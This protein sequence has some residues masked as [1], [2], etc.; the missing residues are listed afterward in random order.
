MKKCLLSVSFIFIA[1]FICT[2]DVFAYHFH[3]DALNA[4]DKGS[5]VLLCEY[6]DPDDP[7]GNDKGEK[8]YYHFRGAGTNSP[9]PTGFWDVFY[10]R[11]SK[12]ETLESAIDQSLLTYGDFVHVFISNNRIS[13]N[14]DGEKFPQDTETNFTC[15]AYSFTDFDNLNEICFGDY[16]TCGAN[17]E[18]GPFPL[19]KN[20]NTIFEVIDKYAS[21]SVYNSISDEEF[22]NGDVKAIIKNRTLEFTKIKYSF[23]T[24]Y[25]MPAFITSYI[26]DIH[27]HVADNNKY[28]ERAAKIKTKADQDLAEGNI[29]QEQHDE[30]VE[31]TNQS[32]YD[33]MGV[34]SVIGVNPCDDPNCYG[35]LGV[36]MTKIVNNIFTFVQFA[37]PILV[38]VLTIVDF[39]K[40]AAAGT[41]DE[42]KK[43]SQ[44]FMKRVIAAMA[45]FFV[46]LI[47]SLFF[48]LAGITV[49]ENCIGTDF[50][51]SN[52]TGQNN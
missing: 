47:C 52:C 43:S 25:D 35:L 24:T 9:L 7:E 28:D 31:K 38:V 27:T 12:Y 20:G 32:Y 37:G 29:D 16:K 17:F 22:L 11:G 33:V 46:P 14:S 36:Q 40:A 44:R 4:V 49:P 3:K 50:E 42:I 18:K 30:I 8:I 23:G 39:I 13:Y 41:Q 26:N 19:Q 15:P 21:D 45:L 10:K 51:T 34:T 2:S 5:A 6:Y 48:D 1:L